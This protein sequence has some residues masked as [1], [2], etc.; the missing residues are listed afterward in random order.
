MGNL[1]LTSYDDLME[2]TSQNGPIV[3]PYYSSYSLLIE[4]LGSNPPFGDQMPQ[5][6]EPLEQSTIDFIA[7]W[8]DEG[9]QN[10]D[11]DDGG[12]GEDDIIS[13]AFQ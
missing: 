12:G 2:G 13:Q 6:G 3:I 11:E 5:N 1:D 10:S 4:K 7:N 8:I 9:A